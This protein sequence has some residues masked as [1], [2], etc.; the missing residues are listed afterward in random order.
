MPPTNVHLGFSMSACPSVGV[1]AGDYS[2]ATFNSDRLIARNRDAEK[3]CIVRWPLW[4]ERS[5]VRPSQ[6]LK[7][8]FS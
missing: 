2:T 8:P 3:A 5:T 1:I 7:A 6:P 4:S